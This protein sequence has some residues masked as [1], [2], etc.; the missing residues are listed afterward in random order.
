MNHRLSLLL[1]LI[2][3]SL[4]AIP[5]SDA[6]LPP[7]RSTH[8]DGTP[9]ARIP[10]DATLFLDSSVAITIEAWV[11]R[12]DASRS[13]PIVGRNRHRSY[14]LGFEGDKLRFYRSGGAFADSTAWV[15]AGHWTHVAASYDGSRVQFYVNGADAGSSLLGNDGVPRAEMLYLGGDADGNGF[16]G[17]LDEVRIWLTALSSS[18]IRSNMFQEISSS[19]GLALAVPKGGRT[20]SH[21][22]EEVFGILPRGLVVPRQTATVTV[23]G[24]VPLD[25]EYREAEQL[26]IR[27]TDGS[28]MPDARAYLVYR[29]DAV[30]GDRALYIGVKGLHLPA[31]GWDPHDSFV[32]VNMDPNYSRE[33]QAMT[34]DFRLRAW[35]DNS[36]PT[37]GWGDGRG[38][39]TVRG[40]PDNPRSWSVAESWPNEFAAPNVEF[41]IARE[42]LGLWTETDG[43]ALGHFDVDSHLTDFLA[44]SDALGGSPASWTPITYGE[45]VPATAPVTVRGLVVDTST[46]S[47]MSGQRVLLKSGPVAATAAVRDFQTTG[48]DGRFAFVG[49][50]VL[51][52]ERVWVELEFQAGR[53]YAPPVVLTGTAGSTV[54]ENRI[55]GYTRC[56]DPAAV[57]DLGQITFNVG[58]PVSASDVRVL[59][60][61]VNQAVQ[62]HLQ[63][64]EEGPDGS[65]GMDV[66]LVAGKDM[67]VRFYVVGR[68]GPVAHFRGTLTA[69]IQPPRG[70]PVLGALFESVDAPAEGIAL[71]ADAAP[72][73]AAHAGSHANQL[74]G[75]RV[76]SAATLNFI[77][78][79][80]RLAGVVTLTLRVNGS[81]THPAIQYRLSTPT[82]LT[83]N[84]IRLINPGALDT[85]LTDD[86]ILTYA[87]VVK[88]LLP[89]SHVRT[90]ITRDYRWGGG[91]TDDLLDDV[92]RAFGG[93]RAPGTGG[94]RPY[95][96]APVVGLSRRMPEPR[97]AGVAWV[98]G[99]PGGDVPLRSGG[100]AV[101]ALDQAALTHEVGHTFGFLHASNLH[102]ESEGGD[103]EDWGA[104]FN[105]HAWMSD[106]P[107]LSGTFGAAI[108]GAGAGPRSWSLI[109][110]RPS[111]PLPRIDPTRLA[112]SA[113]PHDLMSY[114][115]KI[116]APEWISTL[117]YVRAATV[118]YDGR[119]YPA[120]HAA[121]LD[122][123]VQPVVE[124][125][126]VGG[127]RKPN[128]GLT[129][130]PVIYKSLPAP[131]VGNI[132]Q[133]PMTLR[134]FD[135]NGRIVLQTSFAMAEPADSKVEGR[136][137][138]DLAL[139]RMK[140]VQR[141]QVMDGNQVVADVTASRHAPQV[142]VLSPNGGEQI[143]AGRVPV[144][145]TA[146]DADGDPVY[147][148]VQYSPDGGATWQGLNWIK[149]GD[150][151][152][153]EIV[154]AQ[155]IPGRQ[156]LI[157]VVAS[158]G[159]N[160]TVD[161][162]D[163]PFSVGMPN[164]WD[165]APALQ[166]ARQNGNAIVYW[167]GRKQAVMLEAAPSLTGPW[168][169]L[170]RGLTSNGETYARVIPL[171]DPSQY[172]R[173]RTLDASCFELGGF[174]LGAVANP[175]EI[176]GL[177]FVART[178]TGAEAPEG[179][180]VWEDLQVGY[181]ITYQLEVGI[182]DPCDQVDLEV[183]EKSGLV[184]LVAYDEGGAV[185]DSK[186]LEGV[187]AGVQHV[188]LRGVGT[189]IKRVIIT[190]PNARTQ[191]I[192]VCCTTL[193]E[194]PAGNNG[195]NAANG[196]SF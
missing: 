12:E 44:P 11:Y 149:P 118:F 181:D 26:V 60:V 92:W 71:Q 100:T 96:M 31:A 138:F 166:I 70:A 177:K 7:K 9:D 178:I 159:I 19:A 103:W 57:C 139:P 157:R 6:A 189:A 39:F 108:S 104:F 115:R 64:P 187:L 81:M 75:M 151:K 147:T 40:G 143:R 50:S 110:P 62:N 34:N 68:G 117:S 191:L 10:Y 109:D 21:N 165:E 116:G 131:L 51:P 14:R 15:Q 152:T 148:L 168:R 87:P 59:A 179:R 63:Y 86:E 93:D 74:L 112:D 18:Q 41:R 119:P 180:I 173:L 114:A 124:A 98:N 132:P 190:S 162:S 129:L 84:V 58:H 176:S 78:P 97:W 4:L 37:S 171:S 107:G 23:D 123:G 2:Q 102:G 126:L 128:R 49:A 140:G 83:L 121:S 113:I 45:V 134:L 47:P 154:V 164:Q 43:I 85:P 133:G 172:F 1:L 137:M 101:A 156:A 61:E 130:L 35:L 27:Y 72:G 80:D 185:V 77:I 120:V 195:G 175:W 99:S 38:G 167:E 170:G 150:P 53:T 105:P 25:T 106:T 142:K 30:T 55:V 192:S 169:D 16:L 73:E 46:H 193:P 28:A 111:A 66:P 36:A 90:L 153:A 69:E 94:L 125:M 163:A 65:A 56:A 188:T 194:P 88:S 141:I 42:L 184:D 67:L 196:S 76:N 22:Q 144:K 52:G 29:D 13:E 122:G 91:D 33:S 8:Y 161:Q 174:P 135:G 17:N 24:V 146:S 127:M 32:G 155:V 158:D 136:A 186:R 82:T 183:Q 48:P 89:A 54:L 5:K 145:W 3:A 20:A 95:E 182:T 160:V 79:G